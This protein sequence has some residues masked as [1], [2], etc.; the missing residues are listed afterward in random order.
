MATREEVLRA[1]EDVEDPELRRSVVELGMVREIKIEGGVVFV[2]VALTVSGCPL[3]GRIEEDV[4]RRLLALPGVGKAIVKLGVMTE[5]ERRAMGERLHGKQEARSRLL[6]PDSPTR[7]LT[8]ASGKGGVGKSTVTVNLAAALAREGF[9]VGVL[10]ADIYGFSV[11]RLLG[12]QGRRPQVFDKAIVPLEAEGMQVMSMGFFLDEQT[13]VIW[14]GPMLAGAVNQFLNDVLWADLDYLL[15]DLPPG[16]GDVALSLVQRLPRSL[17]I[18]VTTPQEASVHVAARAAHLARKTRQEIAGIVENMA[19]FKCPDCGR[20]HRIFGS[21][22]ADRLAEALGVPVLGRVPLE[23]A[24][25]AGGD[26][27]RPVALAAG[28]SA[29]AEAFR[30]VAREV[31]RRVPPASRGVPAAGRE[32]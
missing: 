6:D 22:G 23:P 29:A 30:A 24:V 28:G 1:L 9:R 4:R 8:V 7:V 25:R 21:G 18:L 13:P 5:E 12:L 3:K 17:M 31:A 27:G 26:E 15:V 14:R 2:E 32:G 19:Y 20:E 11:P 16:T 10:D